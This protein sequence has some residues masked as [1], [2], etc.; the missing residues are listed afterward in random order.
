MAGRQVDPK[1]IIATTQLLSPLPLDAVLRTHKTGL[2]LKEALVLL[3]IVK[4]DNAFLQ[5]SSC[6]MDVSFFHE[7]IA[8]QTASSGCEQNRG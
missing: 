7:E 3:A 6:S 2:I 8:L 5:L 4:D 1:D